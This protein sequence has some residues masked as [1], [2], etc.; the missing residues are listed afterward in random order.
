VWAFLILGII[1]EILVAPRWS[2][3]DDPIDRVEPPQTRT[4]ELPTQEM[5]APVDPQQSE[6]T[7]KIT[8]SESLDP[9][10]AEPPVQQS[11]DQ[12]A[13]DIAEQTTA[14]TKE[15][16]ETILDEQSPFA[17]LSFSDFAEFTDM[18]EGEPEPASQPASSSEGSWETQ[19]LPRLRDFNEVHRY[20]FE[21]VSLELG[22]G[23][24][25]FVGRVFRRAS[26]KYPMVFESVGINDFGD[27]DEGPLLANIQSNLV[28]NY[29]EALDYLI[30][31]ERAMIS[32]FLEMRRAE[33][34]E[35]GLKRI[36]NR[37]ERRVR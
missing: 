5:P 14:L 23:A 24:H 36:L 25:S 4:Q 16:L 26:T 30:T 3:T 18:N 37:R 20:L 1:E 2:D 7:S 12:A 11:N 31:E 28:Q 15:D 35:A 22:A 8:I 27:L 17:E 10:T 32:L 6:D 21:M 19:V 13:E 33:A 34:I 9:Q 29:L